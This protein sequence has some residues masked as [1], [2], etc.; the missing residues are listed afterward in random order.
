MSSANNEIK[1]QYTT[2]KPGDVLDAQYFYYDTAPD[3][4]KQLAI[5]C[6]GYEQ[7]SPN[8]DI[9][10]INYPY[11]FIK[12]TIQGKGILDI[13]SKKINIKPG[14]L[15]GFESGTAHHYTAD[16]NDPMKHYFITFVGS[17][18]KELFSKSSLSKK[19][20]VEVENTEETL[21]LFEKMM[22]LGNN[23][24]EYSQEICCSYLRIIL[25]EQAINSVKSKAS[26]SISMVTYQECK[27]YIDNNFSSIKS[28]LEVA[29][30]CKVDARYMSSLFK[31]YCHISP[32]QYLM[33]LKLNRAANL[34][35][36]TDMTVKEISHEVG[37]IDQYHFS[38]NFKKFHG[39]SPKL[40]RN[41][42]MVD[43]E[44]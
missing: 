8:Y 2:G 39:M 38:R 32:S 20:Y 12:Y 41:K 17:E 25:L 31:R 7:C 10:R 35:L 34:L 24:P 40:Y 14:I 26:L 11:F 15:T 23:R 5:V 28:V 18:S 42:H 44:K 22:S 19:H 21:F 37:F 4:N 36:N 13:D 43:Y 16:P 1:K 3:Y 27:F 9:N 29:N 6:G 30:K 33:R